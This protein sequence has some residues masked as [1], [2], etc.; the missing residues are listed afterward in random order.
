LYYT[1]SADGGATFDPIT[2]VTT[3]TSD[4]SVGSPTSSL[5]FGDY[6]HMTETADGVAL[7]VWTDTRVGNQEIFIASVSQAPAQTYDVTI[8]AH[9]NTEAT[10]VSVAITMDGNPTGFN[11]PHTFSALEGIYTFTVPATDASNH[12]FKQWNTGETSTT[13]TVNSAGTY[14]AYYE[15][16]AQ[17]TIWSS[18][19][20]G[21]PKDVFVLGETV[22]VTVPRIGQIVTLYV[23]ADKTTWSTGDLL[24]DVSTDGAETATLDAPPGTQ[25]IQIWAPPLV[26]GH[27]D[28]VMDVDNDGVFDTGLDLVDSVQIVGFNV[29]PEVP[30]GV[31]M[32]FL[33]MIIALVGFAGF[34]RFRPKI[35]LQ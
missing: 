12:P 33:S 23:V 3:A 13:I 30:F 34:K 29:V 8:N 27:Y 32:A 2:K 15:A 25:T 11:T 31:A 14:T 35:R 20:V 17:V 6:I 1:G 22:Y 26:P 4:V 10:D 21:N 24:T 18:D 5:Y 28:I 7:P 9:C 16:P 19:S